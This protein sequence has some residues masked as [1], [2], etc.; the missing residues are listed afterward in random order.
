MTLQQKV[1]FSVM[2]LCF[3]LCLQIYSSVHQVEIGP[4][5]TYL[6][7]IR[8]GGTVQRGTLYGLRGAYDHT[9]RYL[10]YWG[11][12]GAYS[13]GRLNGKT[14]NSKTIRSHFSEVN[15]EGRIGYTLQS[16]NPTFVSITPFIGVGYLDEKNHYCSPSPVKVHFDNDFFY[17]AA[18]CRLHWNLTPRFEFGLNMTARWGLNGRVK[19]SHDPEYSRTTIKYTQKMQGRISL[20]LTYK[21]IYA[22]LEIEW[23][24]NP[25][26]DYRHYGRKAAVPFDFID[27]RLKSWGGDFSYICRF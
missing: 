2:L 27:T 20:P 16:K 17:G 8:K 12:E 26:F 14:G 24:I 18:G 3:T 9:G 4:E 19:V 13:A 22:G 1:F 11:L 21:T 10:I 6:K 15:L 5:F 25:F 7:R 23:G